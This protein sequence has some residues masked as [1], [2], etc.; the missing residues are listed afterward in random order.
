MSGY[1]RVGNGRSAGV[2][3]LTAAGR[4]RAAR[5]QV[6]K[7]GR[8]AGDRHQASTLCNG[9]A[10]PRSQQPLRVGMC[11]R[12]DDA[13]AGSHLDDAAAIH[14]RDPVGDFD[15]DA[16]VVGDEDTASPNSRWNSRRSRST[17]IRTVASSAVVGSSASRTLAARQRQRDHGALAHAARH[18]MRIIVEPALGRGDAHP[19]EQFECARAP[20]AN[21]ARVSHT[22]RRSDR[23][24]GRPDRRRGPGP[25]TPWRR[26]RRESRESPG[27]TASTSCPSTMIEPPISP[28]SGADA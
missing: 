7:I 8:R 19:L 20:C 9:M 17:W 11:R 4:K 22:A 26:C 24:R 18:L 2:E 25:G 1:H 3:R 28:T 21:D 10:S 15:C 5:R 12:P 23:R 16:D 14:D 27:G 13:G 6:G